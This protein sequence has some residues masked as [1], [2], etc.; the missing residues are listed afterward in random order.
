MR[1]RINPH[2]LERAA[3]RGAT[4]AEIR[5]VIKSGFSIPARGDREEKAKIY[6]FKRERLGRYYNQ[7]RIEVI[8]VHEEDTI[9]TVTVYVFYGHW[10]QET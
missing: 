6:E 3:E 4:E 8:Y 9:T 7:K 5:D 1:I 2:T 10:K